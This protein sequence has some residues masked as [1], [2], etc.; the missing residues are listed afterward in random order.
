MPKILITGCAGFI[1]SHA[2][3]ALL[4]QGYEVV[5]LDNLNDYY[6]PAWKQT[7]LDQFNN[8][9]QFEF[10]KADIT[11]LAALE[12]IFRTTDSTRSYI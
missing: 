6:N 7:N 9:P 2:T 4:K 5:G 11:D 8:Q 1:G 10:I 12:Q 3:Q